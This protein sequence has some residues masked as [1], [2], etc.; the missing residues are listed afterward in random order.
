MFTF[1][2]YRSDEDH[3]IRCL[4]HTL[5]VFDK[6]TNVTMVEREEK[7]VFN[8]AL[9]DEDFLSMVHD[10]LT[11]EGAIEDE[12]YCTMS[13]EDQSHHQQQCLD[14]ETLSSKIEETKLN[15]CNTTCA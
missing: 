7:I 12:N 13:P 9:C 5:A 6:L 2:F 4:Y 11:I 14:I 8:N 15:D 1:L 10:M 3:D